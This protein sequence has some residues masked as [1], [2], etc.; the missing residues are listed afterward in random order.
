[1]CVCVCVCA[2]VCVGGTKTDCHHYKLVPNHDCETGFKLPSLPANR[3]TEID[4]E[5]DRAQMS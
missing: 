2:C 3:V 5:S 1:V 4:G